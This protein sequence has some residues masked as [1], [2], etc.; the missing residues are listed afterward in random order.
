MRTPIVKHLFSI[1]RASCLALALCLL[2]PVLLRAESTRQILIVHSYSQEYPWTRGQHEGFVQT[3]AADA[4]GEFLFSTEYLDTKRRAYDE[5]YAI[6]LA[7]HLRFKYADTKLAAIYLTDDNALLFVRDHLSRVFPGVPVFFSGVN[8]YS[9]QSSLDP[10]FFTGVFERKEF[11]PNIEWLL[12]VDRNANDLLFVGDNSN[13]YQ[14]IES[15]LHRELIPYRLRVRFLAE[16]RLDRLL[17]RLHDL[18]GK[19]LFLTTLGGITDENGQVLPLPEIMKSLVRTGRI[20]ISMEDAYI[21]EGVLGGYVTS[22]RKQGM[23][24]ARLFLAY[25]HG[26]PIVELPPIRE[27]P[28]AWI[29]DDRSLQEHGIDLPGDIRS[30][31]VL[32]QPRPGFY[33][34]FGT[35]IV[36]V[37]VALTVLLFLVVTVSVVFLSRKNRDLRL[38][39]KN[40]EAANALFHQLAEQTRTMHWEV[41]AEGLYTYIS[42]ISEVVTGYRPE[43][44]IGRKHFYDLH[45]AEGREAFKTEAFERFASRGHFLDLENLVQTKD[46]RQIW[47]STHGIPFLDSNGD[48]AGYR[49][50]DTDITERK[51]AELIIRAE[52]DFSDTALNSL[53]G[54][55]YLFDQTGR[56]LRWNRNFEQVTGY[57]S[58]E[59]ARMSPLSLFL[60]ADRTLIEERIQEVFARGAS[61]A[62]ANLVA[63][64]GKQTPYYFTGQTIHVEGRPCLIGT[65]IDI[66][67]RKRAKEV[68]S[69]SEVRQRT[70]LDNMPFLAWLKNTEGRYIMVNQQY[71]QS[72]GRTVDQVV[73]LTDLDIWPREMAEKYRAD[74][75]EVMSMQIGKGLQEIVAVADGPIWVETFKAPIFNLRGEVTGTTGLARDITERKQAEEEK[76]ILEERLNRAEKMEALG[77]LA[78]GVAHDLNNVLGVIV[79]YAELLLHKEGKSSAIRGQLEAMMKGGQRAAAIV[80]DLLTLARRGVL[81]RDVVN[82]NRIIADLPKLPE[83]EGLTSYHPSVQIRHDL[84]PGLPNISGSSVHLSKTLFNLVSNGC[85]A[86]P[87][88]GIVTIRTASQYLDKPIEGYDAV[89]KGNYV[90]LSVSDTGE[91]IPEADLKRIFEPFY[92]K[93]IMGRSGTGLGL[94]VAWGTVKD[95][96][97]YINV[98]S[99]EGKGSTFT[100]YFPTTGEKITAEHESVPLS[101]FMGKGESILI[102]DDVEEQRG[103]A[104]EM[105]A[106]L[107]YGISSVASG[108]EA[109]EYL[110]EH[111]CDLLILDMIMDPGMDG[112]DTY[113]K[114]LE[115][116]PRQKAIIVSGFSESARVHAA[117]ALGA[118]AYVKK[119]YFI[120]KLGLAVRKEL[121]RSKKEA[122][123]PPAGEEGAYP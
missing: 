28:N 95:H 38:T 65:G 92:T 13:T 66:T 89:H 77:I 103:L 19:Y 104:S 116:S 108:E 1:R 105:L 70:I 72:C 106:K 41:N 75:A 93:K 53:P 86:M 115:I 101:Q 54:I 15:E 14:A 26:K 30:Q 67:E 24:A 51:Q 83:F 27:S 59:I 25:E 109:V 46:R 18:P 17:A 33:E 34:N 55:F 61:D 29:F 64:S 118:G 7:R 11:A 63:K 74:D 87:K 20:V 81:G 91:G 5:T 39:Q 99:E 110:K 56:F 97:G 32:L 47:V 4:Q 111:P 82:L 60:G 102:V 121:D 9:V 58:E 119:P 85:E 21:I 45:P 37:L 6:E 8:D 50:S 44:I 43:E 23:N 62:E 100:L 10:A 94:A 68:L 3:V 84:E 123:P 2:A 48:L 69:E 42:D 31:A 112:L 57:S 76:K 107:N 98:H 96:D 90:V 79:G 16:R 12:R 73:G 120:E 78:G 40:A 71:A 122:P 52:R 88:G 49:G 113:R 114:A 35:L 36:G 80:Q 117:Q 22:G